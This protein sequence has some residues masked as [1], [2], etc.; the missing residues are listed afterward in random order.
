[1]KGMFVLFLLGLAALLIMGTGCVSREPPVVQEYTDE[2]FAANEAGLAAYMQKNYT[3]ALGYF[4][5]AIAADPGFP[6]AWSNRGLTLL[7]LDRP[8]EAA[9]AFNRTLEIDPAYPG[10]VQ[11]RDLALSKR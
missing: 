10:A 3:Q 7:A 6:K 1:M 9:D 8:Q 4:D 11:S 5:Q 2:A